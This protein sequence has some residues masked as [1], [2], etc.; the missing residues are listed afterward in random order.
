M[1]P[2]RRAQ[3]RAVALALM[4]VVSLFALAVVPTGLATQGPAS[5]TDTDT[6]TTLSESSV[7]PTLTSDTED[8]DGDGEPVDLE[9]D[10]DEDGEYFHYDAEQVGDYYYLVGDQHDQVYVYD[11]N[12]D[13]LDSHDIESDPGG[14]TQFDGQWV[15]SSWDS[16][17]LNLY[18][19]DDETF[20]DPETIDLEESDI[21]DSPTEP[22]NIDADGDRLYV[23]NEDEI[24]AFDAD[25]EVI[26]RIQTDLE[27]A[28]GLHA[29]DDRLFLTDSD[30]DPTVYEYDLEGDEQATYDAPPDYG[31][32]YEQSTKGLMLLDGDWYVHPS[33]LETT[34]YQFPAT[35]EESDGQTLSGTVENQ[36]GEAVANATVTANGISEAGLPDLDPAD[37]EAEADDLLGELNDPL[38]DAFDEEFDFEAHQETDTPYALVHENSDWGVGTNTIIESSIEDPRVSV[39]ENEE[40]VISIWNPDD[41]GGLIENQ[42]D[43]SFYGATTDGEVVIEQLSPTGEVTDTRTLETEPIA[44]TTGANPLSTTEH[45]GIRTALPPGVYRAYPESNEA[46]GYPFTV[47]SPDQI[48]SGFEDDLRDEA[49]E[50]TDRATQIDELAANDTLVRETTQTDSNGEFELE[51]DDGVTTA[52]VQPLGTPGDSL[53]GLEELDDPTIG[54]LQGLDHDGSFYLPEPDTDTHA[55][56]TD[57]IEL[58]VHQTP[59][60]P[61][62]ELTA[63]DE[64]HDELESALLEEDLSELEGWDE[65]LEDID[66]DRRDELEAAFGDLFEDDDDDD[67]SDDA[68]LGEIHD[69]LHDIEET[70]DIVSDSVEDD[71]DVDDGPISDDEFDVSWAVPDDITEDDATIVAHTADGE[72]KPVDDE[73]WSLETNG[74]FDD[75]TVTLGD[76]PLESDVAVADYE[77]HI[78]DGNE[79]GSDSTTA[80][81]P[82]FDG[83]IPALESLLFSSLNPESGE[84]VSIDVTPQDDATLEVIDADALGPDGEEITANVTDSER[85][86][87][88]ATGDGVH[89]VQLTLESASGHEFVVTERVRSSDRA[90]PDHAVVRGGTSAI[91]EYAVSDDTLTDARLESD[92]ETID[93]EAVLEADDNLGEIHLQPD[94]VLEGSDHEIDLSLLEGPDEVPVSSN[95]AVTTHLENYDPDDAVHWRDSDSITVDGDTRFG[96]V[97][98]QTNDETGHDT[99]LLMTYTDENGEL[100]SLEVRENADWSDRAWHRLDRWLPSISMP[101]LP[102]FATAGEA[103]DQLPRP[104]GWGLSVNSRSG[105]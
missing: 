17:E 85:A 55:P 9:P 86:T 64:L 51:V 68:D 99:H 94:P 13:L 57:D 96:E 48:A 15:I 43:Q 20:D 21:G 29:I 5:S 58:T 101:S 54:D 66:D 81:N 52:T 8:F 39:P 77:I 37:L 102:F 98:T 44:E 73:H 72:T 32:E 100:D 97:L 69:R 23:T 45:H 12:F 67:L 56:P 104:E 103:I 87:F 88:D 40:T 34:L 6:D 2:Q 71:L 62:E 84:R 75:P 18:D 14:I 63:Y 50:L 24:V 70:V 1:P 27:T 47:G 38:P 83:D 74:F 4:L 3:S 7:S 36:R 80:P 31:D 95:I 53:A 60:L 90:H 105:L 42:V 22:W 76:N 65:H 30:T 41:D 10:P 28:K 11:E 26:D 46:G 78:A 82:A 61:F 49:N 25:Y 93:V 19:T 16:N 35:V 33:D 89:H 79:Y 92:G 91:G 59:S